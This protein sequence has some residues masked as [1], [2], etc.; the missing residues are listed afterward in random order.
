MTKL[1]TILFASVGLINLAACA[2]DDDGA[3]TSD[4][5]AFV[6]APE[7][8]VT[9]PATCE[10]LIAIA[11]PIAAPHYHDANL[12]QT[13]GK[14]TLRIGDTGVRVG[15]S[16]AT[17]VGLDSSGAPLGNHDWLFTDAGIRTRNDKLA[18]IPTADPCV[19]DVSSEI[20]V[21]EGSG[22]YAGL[23]GTLQGVG[24]VDFCGAPG[25][26]TITGYLCP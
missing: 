3:D 1:A 13:A 25:R 15:T 11:R 24:S 7:N 22:V 17:I 6:N 16:L 2:T 14:L 5:V 9:A 4:D 12:Q 8:G 18:L 10:P 23:T 21:V 19:F 20:Y 26:V